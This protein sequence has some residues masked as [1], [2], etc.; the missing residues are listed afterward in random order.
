MMRSLFSG[1]S[2]LRV[3]QN[4]MDVIGNN[5]ANV[6][7]V[8]FKAS[9]MTF[10]DAISQRISGASADNP[11]TGRAGRN[12]MQIGLGVNMGGIDNIMTQG[13]AQRTDRP[14]DLTIQGEGFFI[15]SD[16]GGTFFTRAGN[17]DW[18]GHRFSIG[19][20]Q[21]MGWQAIEDPRRPGSFIIEQGSVRPLETPAS[22]HFMNPRPTT[23]VEATGNLRPAD[24]QHDEDWPGTYIITR[25]VEFYDTVGN[26]YTKNVTFRWHPPLN[27]PSVA[28]LDNEPAIASNNTQSVWTFTFG[29]PDDESPLVTIFPNGRRDAGVQVEIAVGEG[30]DATS[31]GF[32]LFTPINATL[33][34]MG[35]VTGV[36]GAG[37]GNGGIPA[38]LNDVAVA[39]RVRQINIEISTTEDG[40]LLPPA[41]PGSPSPP[42][43]IEGNVA[44]IRWDFQAIRAQEGER[45]NARMS[46][47]DGNPPG[48]L[49]DVSFGPDGVITGRYSN[50]HTRILGQIPLAKFR[51]PAGMERVGNNLW[52]PTSNS[53]WFDGVGDHGDLMPG[54]L[55]MSNVD[56]SSEFTE[57][58]ITQ[59]G[60]QANSRI[61]TTSDEMLM[62]LVNLR[63]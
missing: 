52:V 35:S 34:H 37:G 46:F 61:I 40:V 43:A 58:I 31:A 11:E 41:F 60:F 7:T 47:M 10:A 14:L 13:A 5:I 16:Q 50:G 62:E 63:R 42:S 17:V 33:A 27:H 59:R 44:N 8:G 24:A 48:T 51:N 12:P 23:M 6:N 39:D 22:V 28:A 49:R 9:R 25:P 45:A 54:T 53:G 55:E 2:G 29:E 20:M 1:V 36:I 3:H 32:L 30:D 38:N 19:G 56:L 26:R 4:R 15:V 57:M 21:L 18:N